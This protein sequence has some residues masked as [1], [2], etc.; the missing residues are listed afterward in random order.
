MK[1]NYESSNTTNHSHLDHTMDVDE[2]K[3]H[4][5]TA[6]SI[7]ISPELLEK[8][9]LSSQTQI[10]DK[11][12]HAFGNPL[13]IGLVGFLIALTPLSCDLMGWRGA[14]GNGAAGIGAYFFFGGAL[15]VMAGIFGWAMGD[16]FGSAIFA[17][18]GAWFFS[19]AAT[20]VPSFAAFSSYAT[21]GEDPTT[22]WA[23]QGFNAS[24][25]FLTL[26]MSVMSAVFFICSFRANI[27][28]VVIFLALTLAFAFLTAAYW[29]FALDYVGNAAY[30][31]KMVVGAGSSAF[32]AVS[33]G[34]WV[35]VSTMLATLDFPFQLPVGDLTTIIKGASDKS[36][37]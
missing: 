1:D 35:F 33:F 22:G 8:L 19:F 24:F 15:Q 13:P 26:W 6:Q 25:G 14:G 11:Q 3:H 18:Y 36:Q 16:T 37:V 17:T 28:F 34:W 27:C 10:K 5:R 7:S 32:V 23:T 4:I 20:Q 29:Y 12:R 21:P 31:G 9:C 30:A 2:A